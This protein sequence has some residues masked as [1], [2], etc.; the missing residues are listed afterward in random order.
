KKMERDCVKKENFKI[1]L[2]LAKKGKIH[3]SAGAGVGIERLVGW[4][5][6]VE[7]VGETQLFP[8]IPGVVYDL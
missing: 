8:R 1:L 2:T 5:T 7:H 3:P 4:I 6:G